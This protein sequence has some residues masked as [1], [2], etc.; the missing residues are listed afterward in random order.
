MEAAI[1]TDAAAI[2][3]GGE[4]ERGHLWCSCCSKKCLGSVGWFWE[5]CMMSREKRYIIYIYIY[6]II[7]F[8]MYLS[9]KCILSL[10]LWGYSNGN[11]LFYCS[12][13]DLI[14]QTFTPN[15]AL[16]KTWEDIRVADFDDHW[17]WLHDTEDNFTMDFNYF[18]LQ[19]N[20]HISTQSPW[21]PNSW[22]TDA[23]C[24]RWSWSWNLRSS[25]GFSWFFVQPNWCENLPKGEKDAEAI[26]SCLIRTCLYHHSEI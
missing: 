15:R 1:A 16:E 20:S 23:R 21:L 19:F 13:Y 7:S 12:L 17:T 3:P 11:E 24:H 14:W 2:D 9:M 25:V 5:F 18:Q 10:S 8:H 26:K 6:D 22:L 4:G